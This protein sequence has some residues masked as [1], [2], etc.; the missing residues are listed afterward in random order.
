M[1]VSRDSCDL[2]PIEYRCEK[3]ADLSGTLKAE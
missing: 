2:L 1:L 3:A